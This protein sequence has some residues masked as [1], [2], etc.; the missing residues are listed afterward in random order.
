MRDTNNSM[1]ALQRVQLQDQK[2]AF[3]CRGLSQNTLHNL[4]LK[5]SCSSTRTISNWHRCQLKKQLAVHYTC[6]LAPTVG[7]CG[8]NEGPEDIMPITSKEQQMT[9]SGNKAG[10]MSIKFRSAPVCKHYTLLSG[11]TMCYRL[12]TTA[13]IPT[14]TDWCCTS[15]CQTQSMHGLQIIKTN[16]FQSVLAFGR[17]QQH[18][19]D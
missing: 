2:F 6:C 3:A 12:H 17:P 19:Q 14:A 11:E 4:A 10:G 1:C 13:S 16:Q 7:V 5:P 15:S 9:C 8:S 18:V